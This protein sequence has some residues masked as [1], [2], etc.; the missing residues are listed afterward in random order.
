MNSFKKDAQ[1][2]IATDIASRGIDVKNIQTVINYASPKNIET[3]IH[4]IGRAGRAGQMG[5]AYTFL[6]EKDV[7]L[8]VSLVKVFENSGYPVPD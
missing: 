8:A 7:K 5:K 1:V 2:L 4:R 6:T 3:Y